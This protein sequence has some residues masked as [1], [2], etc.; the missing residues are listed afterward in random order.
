MEK[1]SASIAAAGCPLCAA[2][3]PLV[4]P[5]GPRRARPDGKVALFYTTPVE[6]NVPK[7][8]AAA[9]RVL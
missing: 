2:L 6:F 9:V 5:P 8:G 1:A 3:Q 4:P 7:T